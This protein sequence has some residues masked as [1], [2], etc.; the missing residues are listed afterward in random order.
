MESL[1]VPLLDPAPELCRGSGGRLAH[2]GSERRG[3]AG[4]TPLRVPHPGT[5]RA[6]SRAA[7]LLGPVGR[8]RCSHTL[9]TLPGRA[10]RRRRRLLLPGSRRGGAEGERGCAERAG[11][12]LSA[13]GGSEGASERA[14]ER[15]SGA[16]LRSSRASWSPPGRPLDERTERQTDRRLPEA[17]PPPPG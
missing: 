4:R 8:A 5:G 2:V 7:G 13:V 6:C 1:V 11:R 14:S 12:G 15:T 10:R 17:A 3:L 16:F 9:R